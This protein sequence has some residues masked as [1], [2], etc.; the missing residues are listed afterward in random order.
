MN[1]IIII[2]VIFIAPS[3]YVMA[4]TQID[5]SYF[6]PNIQ[7]YI[8]DLGGSPYLIME[9]IKIP[10]GSI[11]IIE[12]GVEVMIQGHYK[13]DVLGS[14]NAIGSEDNRIIFTSNADT[15]WNG[16]RFDFSDN[17]Y[18]ASSKLHYCDISDAQKTGTTCSTSDPESSGG[19][20]YVESFSDL[21]IHECKLFKNSVLGHGGAIGIFNGS[22]PSIQNCTIYDNHAEYRGGGICIMS[23]SSPV[24]HGNNL[25][26][27]TSKKG[28]GAIFIGKLNGSASNPDIIDNTISNNSTSGLNNSHGEGGGI[29]VC[30]SNPTVSGNIFVQNSAFSSGGGI[31][32][33]GASNVILENNIFVGNNSSMDGGALF[34][35]SSLINPINN[36]QFLE[37][38]AVNGGG[39]YLSLLVIDVT[40]CNFTDNTASNHGGGIY[41]LNSTSA[42]DHCTFE[43]NMATANGGGI[44]MDDPEY[45]SINL[46]KFIANTAY[47]GSALYYFRY[48]NQNITEVVNN[49]FVENYATDKAVVYLQGNNN[50]TIFNHNTISNNTAAY[51]ISGLCVENDTY[52]PLVDANNKN[53]HNNIIKESILDIL[54]VTPTWSPPSNYSTLTTINSLQSNPGFISSTDYHLSSTSSCI[55]AGQNYAPLPTMTSTDLDGNQRI[56]NGNT[57]Y[58]CYEYGSQP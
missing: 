3:N 22:N 4:Q 49:L 34:C 54:I 18:P 1:K 53:F 35:A 15:H 52:F 36:C 7:S 12:P 27:N 33:K 6:D 41:V 57:D 44:F 13:I 5:N 26:Q 38:S 47:Q 45:N 40:N 9:D 24:L 16:I 28:G 14:I 8:W 43:G 32:I 31:C 19:A 30:N 25:Y 50:K 58:G 10:I 51:W 56:W 17:S 46:N 55:D 20:I 39:I 23:G 37:N 2:L 42:I 29:F 48:N 21:E 11:L